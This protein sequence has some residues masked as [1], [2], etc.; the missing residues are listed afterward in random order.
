M[1]EPLEAGRPDAELLKLLRATSFIAGLSILIVWYLDDLHG[2]VTA[3]EACTT[4]AIGCVYLLSS[5]MLW[6]TPGRLPLIVKACLA[7][8]SLYFLGTLHAATLE[9][10]IKSLYSLTSNAQFMP[11]LYVA[12]F[13]TLKRGAATLSWLHYAGIALLY[14]AHHGWPDP[15]GLLPAPEDA[16]G[17]AWLIVLLSHPCYIL[18]LQYITLLKDRLLRS[19][20]QAHADKQHFL[21]MLSHEIRSPLQAMLGSID[22]LALK[23]QGP[24]EKRAVDRLRHAAGQ[25]DGH[26]RD[27]TEFTRLEDPAWQLHLEDV[28][29][30]ALVRE[31]CDTW[32]AQAAAKGLALYWEIA[33]HHE[34]ALRQVRTDP[35]RLR[36]ILGNLLSNAVKYTPSGHIT[37]RA[38][39]ADA[40]LPRLDVSDTGVGIPPDA[41]A[42]IFQPY[43]RLEDPRAGSTEG[44]GL[45]LAV[46]QR[47]VERLQGKLSVESLPE[48]GSSFSVLLPYLA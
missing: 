15:R 22:L 45:G 3:W 14:A 4:V 27:V 31:V 11:M 29:L 28:D 6:L 12:A 1:V 16:T 40:G 23:V 17:H 18:A 43:V 30:P 7:A 38:S 44:S 37:V 32:Q 21:A 24:P 8:T 48:Q 19:Q 34:A 42:R 13:I 9:A 39:V 26:L 20:R 36:Q 5:L 41:L 47:L 2:M 33:A 46:V 35:Q 10:P 25:L